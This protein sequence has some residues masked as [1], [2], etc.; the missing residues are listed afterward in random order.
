MAQ[1]EIEASKREVAG[2][3]V[4]FLRR[5]GMTPAAL[6]GHGIESVPI[7]VDTKLLEQSLAKAGKTDLIALK[8]DNSKAPSNVLVRE[9]QR[10]PITR[11][12]LH[13]NFYQVRMTE[14][15]KA[16][17]PLVLHGEAPALKVKGNMILHLLDS[18]LIEALP[19]DLPHSLEVD[20]SI[21]EETDQAI[22]VKDIPLNA[23]IALLS[24]PEQMVVKVAGTAK[25]EV[26]EVE[27]EKE[28]AVEEPQAEAETTAA[29][30]EE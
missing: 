5:A 25:A 15:I 23:K 28:V 9:V 17:V 2:K 10:T 13:V 22:Y 7:Q 29:S 27:V 12:L 21:L 3:K 20:L 16:E 4:R 8:I 30:A 19:G 26:E 6:Y 24:D 14:K 1:L 11:E 18:L